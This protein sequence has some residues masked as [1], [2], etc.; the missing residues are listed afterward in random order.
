M[1]EV[2]WWPGSPVVEIDLYLPGSRMQTW[3]EVP[4]IKFRVADLQFRDYTPFG[5]D[6]ETETCSLLVDAAH[7]GL[8]TSWHGPC[9]L[10]T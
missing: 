4:Y 5:W 7:K 8:G 3:V 1:L 9:K 6:A 10:V 2:R